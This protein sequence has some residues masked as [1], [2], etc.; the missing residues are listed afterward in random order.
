MYFSHDLPERFL[1]FQDT[2]MGFPKT[3]SVFSITE[4]EQLMFRK[5]PASNPCKL[6]YNAMS[7]AFWGFSL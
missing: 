5:S 3:F 2:L 1:R 6:H 4:T 7:Y